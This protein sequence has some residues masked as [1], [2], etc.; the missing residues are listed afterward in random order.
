M[1][2]ESFVFTFATED[3]GENFLHNTHVA[4]QYNF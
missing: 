4:S 1:L 3:I 2:S